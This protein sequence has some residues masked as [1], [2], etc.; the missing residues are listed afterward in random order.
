VRSLKN[1]AETLEPLKKAVAQRNQEKSLEAFN[2]FLFQFT[3]V[4]GRNEKILR[5][6]VPLLEGLR[7]RI[8]AEDYSTACSQVLSL[9][10]MFRSV[11]SQLSSLDPDVLP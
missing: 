9:Q 6:T 1:L 2:I 7:D 5:D 10:A 4:F 8:R 3:G 11:V